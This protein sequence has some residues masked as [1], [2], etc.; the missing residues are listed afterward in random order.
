MKTAID[1][2]LVALAAA[3]MLTTLPTAA[4]AQKAGAGSGDGVVAIDQ[5]KALN[6]NVT[7]GDAAGFPVRIS[8][9]GSYRLTSDL[10]VPAGLDGIQVMS[11]V[12][13]V[14]D[15]AGYAIIGPANCSRTVNCYQQQG[16]TDGIDVGDSG[17]VHVSRGKIRGFTRAGL[18]GNSAGVLVRATDLDV[19]GNGMGIMATR[20]FATRIFAEQNAQFGIY[21]IQGSIVDSYAGSNHVGIGMSAGSVRGSTSYFNVFGYWLPA[22]VYQ[23]NTATANN[24]VMMVAPQHPG[25]NNGF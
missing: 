8:Q 1:L 4:W 19:T 25:S 5:T 14:I 7:A 15:M 11:G 22:A 18:E 23:D 9:S 6:G 3:T 17:S 12:T 13:A 10:V 20:L 21:A 16:G 2:K 24:A